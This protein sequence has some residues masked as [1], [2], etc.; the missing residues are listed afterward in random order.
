VK[1]WFDQYLLEILPYGETMRIYFDVFLLNF[2]KQMMKTGQNRVLII[3]CRLSSQRKRPNKRKSS[4]QSSISIPAAIKKTG[5]KTF[6][7]FNE[8]LKHQAQMKNTQS[9]RWICTASLDNGI[10]DKKWIF[11][12]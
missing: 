7:G 2:K 1:S 4:I 5:I 3:S 12:F 8:T 11:K 9:P 10:N 6:A